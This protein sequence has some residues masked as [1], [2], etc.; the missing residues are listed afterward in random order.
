MFPS[1]DEKAMISAA[2]LSMGT[3]PAIGAVELVFGILALLLWRWRPFFVIN[4]AL[5]LGALLS[6]AVRSPSYL[7]AAFN[8]VTLNVAMIILSALGYLSAKEL[9]SAAHCLRRPLK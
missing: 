2:G 6:V 5:M 4:A 8:P 7:F 1:V 9:P 3:L